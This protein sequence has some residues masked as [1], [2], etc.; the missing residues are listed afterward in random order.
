MREREES[1]QS[2]RFGGFMIPEGRMKEELAARWQLEWKVLS[3][4]CGI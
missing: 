3:D 1:R 2:P 4:A